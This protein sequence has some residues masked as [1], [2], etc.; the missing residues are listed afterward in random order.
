MKNIHL[1]AGISSLLLLG[2][3]GGGGSDSTTPPPPPPPPP[4]SYATAL[5]YQDPAGTGF[6]LVRSAASTDTRL[7]LELLG[8]SGTQ[9]KGV[10]F[11]LSADTTKVN[12]VHPSGITGSHVAA[13]TVFP[14][15]SAPRLSADKVTGN[16]LQVGLFQKGGSATTL[17]SA[18]ILSLALDLKGA[19]IAKGPVNFASQSGKQA[20]LLAADGSLTPISLSVGTLS[21]Q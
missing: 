11:F 8:P 4:P 14:V 5:A 10:A 17:G 21:A 13:G 19:T 7:V 20:V 1:F 9:G 12:W 15:G 16:Q 3:C 18:P 6:R 2:A